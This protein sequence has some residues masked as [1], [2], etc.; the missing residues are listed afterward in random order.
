MLDRPNW[1]LERLYQSVAPEIGESEAI[2][3]SSAKIAEP[4]AIGGYVHEPLFDRKQL[5]RQ[6]FDQTHVLPRTVDSGRPISAADRRAKAG[7]RDEP[8][9]LEARAAREQ[10]ISEHPASRSI[11][12][13]RP[14]FQVERSREARSAF[15]AGVG[16][17]LS[18]SMPSPSP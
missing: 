11:R 12:Q 3:H 16:S 14:R 13:P 17:S 6:R 18:S 2:T 7:L 9:S 15:Q 1:E 8:D 10:I 4:V 5:A